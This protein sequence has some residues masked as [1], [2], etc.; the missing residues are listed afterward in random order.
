VRDAGSQVRPHAPPS[1]PRIIETDRSDRQFPRLEF[2]E[3]AALVGVLFLAGLLRFHLI[4]AQSLWADEGNSWAMTLRPLGAIA[5]A[6]SGDVHPPLYYYLLNLWARI[7]GTSE[8]GLRSLSAVAGWLLVLATY[9]WARRLQGP[10]VGLVAGLV[11]AVSPFAIYYSQEARAYSLMSLLAVACALTFTAHVQARDRGQAGLL[12][13]ALY[14]VTGA[15]LLWTHYLGGALLVLTNVF[16]LLWLAARQGP[17][18]RSRRLLEWVLAQLAVVALYTPWLPVMLRTASEWPAI[19]EPRNLGYYLGEAARLYTHGP[20]GSGIGR[21]GILALAVAAV[22]ALAGWLRRR[23]GLLWA[24][25]VALALWVPLVMWLMSLV[26]PAY[27]AKFML[28][29]LAP[30]HVL[31]G[32]AAVWLASLL[33]RLLRGQK[34]HPFSAAVPAALLGAALLVPVALASAGGVS[35]VY[36]D[37]RYARDDYRAISGYLDA[38]AGVGD[39]IIL[40]APGQVEVFSYYYHGPAQVYPLPLQRPADR[41]SV[42]ATLEQ[43]AADNRRAF[44]VLWATGESDPQSHVETWLNANSYKSMDSW[45]GNVRLAAYELP[46]APLRHES[47]GL[48]FGETAAL[49]DA[50]LG[51]EAVAPGCAWPVALRWR[52]QQPATANY[53]VF[54]QALD[55]SNNIVGQRD[56]ELLAD[57]RPTT[58]WAI[59][60]ALTDRQG[61]PIDV[62]TPPG[63]YRVVA[64]LYD[65][66]T[67]ARLKLDDGSD[68]VELGQVEVTAAPRPVPIEAIR[69]LVR[70][71]I[72]LGPVRLQGW[73]CGALGST[74][75]RTITATAGQPLSIVLYWTVLQP[76]AVGLEFALQEGSTAQALGAQSLLQGYGGVDALVGSLARDP[77]TVFLPPDLAPGRYRLSMTVKTADGEGT[78]DLAAVVVAGS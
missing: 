40:N 52:L 33:F 50:A 30:F 78:V 44:V 46:A 62:G 59:G 67:G 22:G 14:S 77:H 58:Q 31:T 65:P 12:P 36:Y 64:G 42:V 61:V 1:H 35:A 13:L 37:G 16:A 20:A 28:L 55:G 60:E 29:G 63:R 5:A 43:I 49:D 23:D 47:L 39:A 73:D 4:G 9:A 10:M 25:V 26:R 48:L 21:A 70:A 69:P 17:L 57:G 53:K 76:G 72:N 15:A 32:V 38:A 24:L 56:A 45:Y 6:V 2:P 3:A 7:A 19:S 41:E 27:R 11:A 8:A 74:P 54:L 68:Y 75:A 66:G 18:P 71:H 51:T 34:G